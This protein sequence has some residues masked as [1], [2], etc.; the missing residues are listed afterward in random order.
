MLRGISKTLHQ[1][2]NVFIYQWQNCFIGLSVES[3]Q[4]DISVEHIHSARKSNVQIHSEELQVPSAN[5]YENRILYDQNRLG[6]L[7]GPY[8]S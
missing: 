1:I 8:F 3:I 5:Q 2:F 7:N 6:F 4:G